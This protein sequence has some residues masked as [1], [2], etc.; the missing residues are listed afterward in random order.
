MWFKVRRLFRPPDFSRAS[1]PCRK[2]RTLLPL[3]GTVTS[4]PIIRNLGAPAFPSGKLVQGCSFGITFIY[5]KICPR[6]VTDCHRTVKSIYS[7]ICGVRI[8]T[9]SVYTSQIHTYPCA[10]RFP[11]M[12]TC[13]ALCCMRLNIA[14]AVI[15]GQST[16]YCFR[17][18]YFGYFPYRI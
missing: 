1:A 12:Q 16:I 11:C 5:F 9:F 4:Q 3:S 18:Y 6:S 15:I 7:I 10:Y 14:R 2:F 8:M 17:S 13:R